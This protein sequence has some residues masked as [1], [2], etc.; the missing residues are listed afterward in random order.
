MN[1]K[2]TMGGPE[3]ETYEDSSI[4]HQHVNHPNTISPKYLARTAVAT[5]RS[6]PAIFGRWKYLSL[7]YLE[8]IIFNEQKLKQS[9]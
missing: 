1:D 5:I 8:Q 4:S 2:L 6:I 7:L 9:I 3:I